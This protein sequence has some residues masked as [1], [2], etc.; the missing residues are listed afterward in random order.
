MDVSLQVAADV[1]ETCA[2]RRAQPLVTD[3]AFRDKAK[4]AILAGPPAPTALRPMI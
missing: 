3:P 2:L 1:Q 4:R